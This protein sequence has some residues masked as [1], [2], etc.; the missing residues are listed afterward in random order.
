MFWRNCSHTL[1]L[2]WLQVI[3]M[4]IGHLQTIIVPCAW[5]MRTLHN[6]VFLSK[7]ASVANDDDEFLDSCQAPINEVGLIT[8]C[9]LLLLELFL[10]YQTCWWTKCTL[11][12]CWLNHFYPTSI[13]YQWQWNITLFCWIRVSG[14]VTQSLK[15]VWVGLWGS[16]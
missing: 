1:F 14:I 4:N 2:Q 11:V 10:P 13:M 5:L 6:I 8:L 9:H 7:K 3:M 12:P 15:S 16:A